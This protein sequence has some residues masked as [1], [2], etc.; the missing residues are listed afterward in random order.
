M[1]QILASDLVV[2]IALAQ[3]PDQETLPRFWARL[4]NDTCL[5]ADLIVAK[6]DRLTDD[7]WYVDGTPLL[8]VEV[9]SMAS[10]GAD[11]GAKKDLWARYGL[12]AYWVVQP[13]ASRPRILVFELDGDAYVERAQLTGDKPYQVKQPFD[14]ELVPDEIFGLRNRP[15]GKG[16][17][18]MKEQT[19]TNLPSADQRILIDAFGHR[20]P[21]GAEKA[22]LW[23]GCPV[24]YGVW[25]ERDVEIAQRAYP[26]RVI[27]L[28]Q[29][30]GRPGTM[31]VLPTEPTATATAVAG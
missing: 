17:T 9:T 25:D 3:P 5:R 20:W 13:G 23:D 12:P 19:G 21:T 28:D 15:A 30:P 31:R 6:R 7:A 16:R 26:G 8:A 2:P 29:E 18:T 4:A 1:H 14:M 10:V 22:E 24:F 11:L 27:Q